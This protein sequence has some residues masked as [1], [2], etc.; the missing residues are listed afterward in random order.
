MAPTEGRRTLGQRFRTA[1][2]RS[3]VGRSSERALF[4]SALERDEGCFSLLYIHGPGGAGKT[5]L[6]RVLADDARAAGRF[7]VEVDLRETGATP[8]AFEAACAQAFDADGVVLLIDTFEHSQALETWL[9]IRFLPRL[10]FDAL[11]V[12]AGRAA[13]DPGWRTDPDWSDALRVVALPDLSTA[14][15]RSLLARRGIPQEPFASLLNF[16]GGQPLALTL[17]TDLAARQQSEPRDWIPDQEVIKTLL[18]RLV[19]HVPSPAHRR[20]LEVCAHVEA[21]T[22]EL[23][24]SAVGQDAANLFEWLRGLPFIESG[25]FGVYPHDVVREVLNQD[26]RWRDPEGFGSLRRE[27]HEH[28]LHRVRAA[29]GPEVVETTRSLLYL[30]RNVTS[31]AGYVSWTGR[32]EVYEDGYSPQDRA[33]VLRLI[34]DSDGVQLARIVAFWIDQQPD[35][36]HLHRRA[37]TD[38]VIAFSAWLRLSEPKH[39]EIAADPVVAAV[40]RY[41]DSHGPALPGEHFAVARFFI[42]AA[43]HRTISP[44]VDLVFTRVVAEWLR[45]KRTAWTFLVAR[46]SQRWAAQAKAVEHEPTD[47]TVKI[48]DTEF[49]LYGHDWRAAPLQQWFDRQDTEVLSGRRR[50]AAAQPSHPALLRSQFDAAVRAALRHI[51]RD[52]ALDINPLCDTVLV[53]NGHELRLLITEALATLADDPRT[54]RQYRAVHATFFGPAPTQEATA[55]LLG[56]PFSTYRRHLAGGTAM[57]CDL[58]WNQQPNTNKI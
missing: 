7:V 44:A 13:L 52:A 40:W 1:R 46:E 28:L 17:S 25:R 47:E 15:A 39:E 8:S 10:P 16:A 2:T 20:A 49:R 37:E 34:S 42:D 58:L 4:S 54:M 30:Y 53:D 29:T 27:I 14:E 5:T 55:T 32:G 48:G 23:L 51:R 9:R 45:A 21:T 24:R 35:A 56:L 33:D 12:I 6:L 19:G 36:F 26:L 3:F 43:S 50:V 31:V 18:H 11:V 41:C 57:V 22:E 38:E